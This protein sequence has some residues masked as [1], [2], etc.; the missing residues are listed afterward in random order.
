MGPE[1]PTTTAELW[2]MGD[3]VDDANIS[4]PLGQTV[5][6]LRPTVD[7]IVKEAQD[8]QAKRKQAEMARQ[9]NIIA[10]QTRMQQRQTSTPMA[11][12]KVTTNFNAPTSPVGWNQ[13]RA[14]LPSRPR[15]KASRGR[16]APIMRQS[17]GGPP[18]N[19]FR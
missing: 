17:P 13:P 12:P 10:E 9:A 16:S 14:Q 3:S 5:S 4:K 1:N 19:R 8:N 6:E 15:A 2:R 18:M 7:T 11:A